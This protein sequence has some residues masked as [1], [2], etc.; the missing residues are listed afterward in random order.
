MAKF[1]KWIRHGGTFALNLKYIGGKLVGKLTQF[2]MGYDMFKEFICSFLKIDGNKMGV[3]M[4]FNP[5]IQEISNWYDIL[6]DD[7]SSIF[8][9]YTFKNPNKYHLFVSIYERLKE[10]CLL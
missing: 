7:S 8:F 2:E 10:T 4:N 6:D 9:C 1:S 3:N 5:D